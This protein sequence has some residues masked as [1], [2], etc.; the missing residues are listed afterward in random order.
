[1]RNHLDIDGWFNYQLTYDFLLSKV[2]DGG[3]FV[4]CGAWLGKSSSYL[5]DQAKDRIKVYIVDT[6][7]GSPNET[8]NHQILVTQE[9]IYQKFLHNMGY[10]KYTPLKMDSCV[11]AAT[12]EDNSLDVVYIDMTHTYEAVKQDIACWL[13]KVKDEGYIAGHDYAAYAPGVIQAVNEA[14]GDKVTV[15]DGNCWIVKKSQ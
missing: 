9:D 14:F 1:M 5:C 13:P 8:N 2:P 12:F 11:A 15:M 10:R 6:W 4:E 7:E 3:T